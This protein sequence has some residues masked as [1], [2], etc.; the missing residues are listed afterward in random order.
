MAEVPFIKSSEE[1]QIKNPGGTAFEFLP[2]HYHSNHMA[3]NEP[4]Q[5]ILV[6]VLWEAIREACPVRVAGPRKTPRG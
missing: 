6:F 1:L 3:L 2:L 4:T 5:Q